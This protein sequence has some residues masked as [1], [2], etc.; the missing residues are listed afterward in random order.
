MCSLFDKQIKC[1]RKQ[2]FYFLEKSV[3]LP[4]HNKYKMFLSQSKDINKLHLSFNS[5]FFTFQTNFSVPNGKD[6]KEIV[7][8][9]TEN[10][11]IKDRDK[12][13][14]ELSPS[15]TTATSTI[16]TVSV[17]D[18]SKD[19]NSKRHDGGKSKP[20][21]NVNIPKF[22][23]PHGKPINKEETEK[24]LD[25]VSKEFS[26]LEGGKAFLSNFGPITKVCLML[27]L[28]QFSLLTSIQW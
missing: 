8:K 24:I 15:L 6:V 25:K 13:N 18:S 7:K 11:F 20:L 27:S 16:T 9:E 17:S 3:C 28:T 4:L 1:Q 23:Y 14:K 10:E 19:T 22:Y 5:F 26:K 2:C 12:E 21:Q